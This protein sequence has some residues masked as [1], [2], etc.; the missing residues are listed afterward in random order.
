MQ[1]TGIA[2]HGMSIPSTYT[3]AVSELLHRLPGQATRMVE[4]L[5]YSWV[6]TRSNQH[7]WPE[8]SGPELP[9]LIIHSST[10]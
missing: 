3:A 2:P 9:K 8:F 7:N 1:M 10:M 4:L 5:C 6:S